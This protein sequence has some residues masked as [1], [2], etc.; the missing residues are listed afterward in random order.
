VMQQADGSSR[1]H[2]P[3]CGTAQPVDD[4]VDRWLR[5]VAWQAQRSS[6][7]L[8]AKL[9]TSCQAH[10]WSHGV[11]L[12]RHSKPRRAFNRLHQGGLVSTRS[13]LDWYVLSI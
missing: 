6:D 10:P 3:V 12:G 9:L 4:K 8:D 5:Q 1:L 11:C 13:H 2:G 7:C